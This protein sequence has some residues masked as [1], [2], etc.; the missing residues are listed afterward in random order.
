MPRQSGAAR[1]FKVGSSSER[2]RPPSELTP[3]EK[4][5]FI[6]L[7][8]NNK[9]EHFRPSDM[10]LLCAYVHA[11][12]VEATLAKYIAKD[13][14]ALLRWEKA[15]RVL[16]SLSMRL[17]LSPQSRTPT[18]TAPRP[19]LERPKPAN[20]YETMRLATNGEDEEATQ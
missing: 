3:A 12:A 18:H 15:C 6:E 8:A 10:P 20:Y 4:K 5:I 16:T 1:T 19:S 7:V 14:K 13:E 11:C 2:L 17:R 9:P